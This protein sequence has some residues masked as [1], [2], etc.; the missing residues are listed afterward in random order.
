[1]VNDYSLSSTLDLDNRDMFAIRKD[2]VVM[3]P[4]VRAQRGHGC[5]M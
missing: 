2:S 5:L 4:R 1:M 3:S